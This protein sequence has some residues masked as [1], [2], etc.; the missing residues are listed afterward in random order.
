VRRFDSLYQSIRSYALNINT[1]WAYNTLRQR[2]EQM[3]HNGE[4]ITGLKLADELDLYS[5]RRDSYSRDIINLIRKD[6]LEQLATVRLRPTHAVST[7]PDTPV[8]NCGLHNSSEMLRREQ[9]QLL[10]D[11]GRN[12]G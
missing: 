4:L 8:K 1:H 11:A 7:T 9:A 3:R 6:Q 5:A 10:A 2:R 12:Q